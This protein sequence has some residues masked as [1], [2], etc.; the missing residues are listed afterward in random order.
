MVW[1][2]RRVS[3]EVQTSR[4]AIENEF[5]HRLAGGYAVADPPTAVTTS[6]RSACGIT[7]YRTTVLSGHIDGWRQLAD[8]R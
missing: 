1:V 8:D 2:S 3:L 5:R 7:S 6:H 4:F